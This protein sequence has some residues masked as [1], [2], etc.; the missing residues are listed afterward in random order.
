MDISTAEHDMAMRI[1][2]IAD[3]IED[4][5]ANKPP[6]L[7]VLL[8]HR[9]K[10]EAAAA[11][12]A[13]ADADVHSPETLRALQNDIQRFRDIARWIRETVDQAQEIARQIEAQD[14]RGLA[15]LVN[16]EYQED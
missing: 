13:L 6:G 5:F 3:G 7:A 8:L 10:Q 4:D 9:A 12:I 14:I 15:D 1:L 16:P 2:T 11:M